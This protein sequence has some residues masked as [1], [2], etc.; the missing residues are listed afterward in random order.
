MRILKFEPS[1]Q[2]N[3]VQ[4]NLYHQDL[5]GLVQALSW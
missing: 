2:V 3:N 1:H 5:Q 4:G